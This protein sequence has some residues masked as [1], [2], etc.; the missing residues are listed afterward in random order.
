[1]SGPVDRPAVPATDAPRPQ[2]RDAAAQRTAFVQGE[3]PGN[4]PDPSTADLFVSQASSGLRQWG[5][6]VREEWLPELVGRQG[7]R[8]YREMLD[9][10]PVIGAIN[11]AITQSIRQ[12]E[13]RVEPPDDS[14]AAAEQLEFVESLMHD[15]SDSWN[16]F[17][18]EMLTMLPFGYAPHEIVYKR[19]LGR[20]PPGIDRYGLPLPQ[21]KYDDGL[22]GIRSLPLRGQDTVLK[23]FFNA[24][25]GIA[26][27][28]QQP[29][30]GPIVDLSIK[31]MLLFRAR[32]TKNNPE[33]YSILRTAYRPYYFSKRLEEQEGILLER[34]SGVPEYRLPKQVLDAA[35]S[36]DKV[37]SAV[38]AQY[39]RIIR[40]LKVDEQMGLITP[41]DT[42]KNPDGS[43]S[44]V[45]MYEFK[46]N[47]PATGGRG[48]QA[49]NVAIERHKLDMMTSVLADFLTLGHSARG[50]QSLAES[51]VDIFFQ[52]IEGWVQSAA[53]VLNTH[54][55]PKL[56]DLNGID[57]D[58]MPEFVPDMP[59]RVDLDGLSNYVLRL[60]QAGA[61]LF[62]DEDTENYLRE[63]AGMP[64]I[65][66]TA[67]AR[68]LLNPQSGDEFGVQSAQATQELQKR[69]AG[70]M[71]KRMMRMGQ[72]SPWGD[73][74]LGRVGKRRGRRVARAPLNK[75]KAPKT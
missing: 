48:N 58:L 9:N 59:Q 55:L 35:A 28:T 1:M 73:D 39:Q 57:F 3:T 8:T 4:P 10:S 14:P 27:M 30:T 51:K 21:S 15:M 29:W 34:M 23:W 38:V 32:Q 13:W 36:G 24:N 26:G 31:K 75:P 52:A 33:G 67:E 71:A 46:F 17:L 61:A 44:A 37:S 53:A 49:F 63:V 62:P 25:G 45:P 42:F 40:N 64:D 47:M 41:S 74:Q 5:G 65:A 69:L 60:S 16:D 6:W 72:M 70:M 68:E 43:P 50:T 18:T 66:D 20:N 7:A 12:V 54:L 2:M 56:W 11:F 19:R 22:I